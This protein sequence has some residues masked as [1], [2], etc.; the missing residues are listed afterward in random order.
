MKKLIFIIF[1]A[2]SFQSCEKMV[3][4]LDKRPPYQA[5]L[6][7]AITNAKSAE[8]ALTGVYSFLP[9]SSGFTS[10]WVT[11]QGSFRAGAM[12][13]PTFWTK[14]NAVY[15]YERNWPVLSGT[16]DYD[17]D[18]DYGMIKNAN[19]LLKALE[20]IDDFKDGRKQ[21]MIGELHFLRGFAYQRLLMRYCEYWD[22]NSPLGLIIRN[23]L[24]VIGNLAKPRSTVKES[25][26]AIIADLDIAIENC[27]DYSRCGY[28]SNVAAKAFKTQLLFNMGKYTE[29]IA[30]ANDI[31]Q[32][33][34]DNAL[35]SSYGSIFTDGASCPE[36]IF[37]REYASSDLTSLESRVLDFNTGKWGPTTSYIK[38]LGDDPADDVLNPNVD[39]RYHSIIGPRITVPYNYG[40][41]GQVYTNYTVKKLTN[42]ANDLPLI[43]M[44][45]AEIYLLKA[46]AI[47]RSGGSFADAYA[48]IAVLRNRAGA[49]EV[50]HATDEEIK[51]AICNEWQI[52]MSFENNQEYLAL[53]RFGVDKLLERNDLLRTAFNQAIKNG[54][55]AEAQ[56]VKRMQDFRILPIPSSEINGNP[57]V[58]NPGY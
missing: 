50:P 42:T 9:G 7:G 47:Y 3:D 45:T 57:V 4:V 26:D 16:M 2:L 41:P 18:A 39:P 13:K 53:R 52:E 22:I 48:P 36:I 25:Y 58:Q 49:A 19:F 27:P 6:E 15:Y 8:L 30:L 12:A 17:W 38:L 23:E 35:A 56:Y 28:A 43:F 31:I 37:G 1:L 55:A 54:S 24:P 14:G 33:Y 34:P 32:N 46:E 20:G 21:E 51:N 40:T 11:V 44:R 29:C 5:D 10:Y